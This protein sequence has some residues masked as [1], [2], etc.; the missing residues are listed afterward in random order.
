MGIVIMP[1][2]IG[3][4]IVTV[5]AIKTSIVLFNTGTIGLNEIR[6]GLLISLLLFAAVTASYVIE[7]NYQEK[8][9]ASFRSVQLSFSQLPYKFSEWC[10]TLNSSNSPII[11][12]ICWTRGSQNSNTFPQSAQIR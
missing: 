5:I 12:L 9:Y 1:F 4:L 10:V 2:V 8:N 7:G 11:V 3:A 6:F